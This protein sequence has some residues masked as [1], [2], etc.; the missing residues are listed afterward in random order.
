MVESKR[1]SPDGL[2]KKRKCSWTEE[3]IKTWDLH[4]M[5][6]YSAIKEHEIMPFAALFIL[7]KT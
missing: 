2:K 6:Y 3:L 4:I 5:E 1:D 7:A